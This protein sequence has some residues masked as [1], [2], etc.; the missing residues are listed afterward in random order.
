MYRE[1]F[2]KCHFC[3]SFDLISG[4]LYDEVGIKQSVHV[5]MIQRSRNLARIST[6]L[7][8]DFAW[9]IME[10]QTFSCMG[11]NFHFVSAEFL[12]LSTEY[13]FSECRIMGLFRVPMQVFLVAKVYFLWA[14]FPFLSAEFRRSTQHFLAID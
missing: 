8:R 13:S 10:K 11:E 4:K 5:S 3:Y 14:Q 6:E 2:Q 9:K 7:Q 1:K 12:F